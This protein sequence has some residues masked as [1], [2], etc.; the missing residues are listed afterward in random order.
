MSAELSEVLAILD[1]AAAESRKRPIELDSH[2]NV[3]S[4]SVMEGNATLPASGSKYQAIDTLVT[5]SDKITSVTVESQQKTKPVVSKQSQIQSSSATTPLEHPKAS[6]GSNNLVSAERKFDSGYSRRGPRSK[7]TSETVSDDTIANDDD[8]DDDEDDDSDWRG[9]RDAMKKTAAIKD[10]ESRKPEVWGAYGYEES[11]FF[12]NRNNSDTVLSELDIDDYPSSSEDETVENDIV[13]DVVSI[14]IN[15]I[16][17]SENI[18]STE[19]VDD[20]Q[21][22]DELLTSRSDSLLEMAIESQCDFKIR[23]VDDIDSSTVIKSPDKSQIESNDIDPPSPQVRLDSAD[24]PKSSGPG[25]ILQSASQR[26]GNG[27]GAKKRGDRLI[28]SVENARQKREN[29]EASSVS[30][31]V[32]NEFCNSEEKTLQNESDEHI[33]SVDVS[34]PQKSS[35]N[36][37]TETTIHTF[38]K[39]IENFFDLYKIEVFNE[40]Y[41][42]VVPLELSESLL[43]VISSSQS[44]AVS[45]DEHNLVSLHGKNVTSKIWK[46][47]RNICVLQC[48]LFTSQNN[49][50]GGITFSPL[51]IAEKSD[52]LINALVSWTLVK[53]TELEGRVISVNLSC[54]DD[55]LSNEDKSNSNACKILHIA[56]EGVTPNSILFLTNY[57]QQAI[58]DLSVANLFQSLNLDTVQ[59]TFAPN[60]VNIQ[61]STFSRVLTNTES[62]VALE[63]MALPPASCATGLDWQTKL[64]SNS[65]ATCVLKPYV[66]EDPYLFSNVLF[67]CETYGL[68]LCGLRTAYVDPSNTAVNHY[69]HL[70]SSLEVLQYVI[71][72]SNNLLPVI[73]MCYY[74]AK[75]CA[76]DVLRQALGPEDPT[77][78]HRTDPKSVRALYGQSRHKNIAFSF[79]SLLTNSW[80]DTMYWFG[81][82]SNKCYS[83]SRGVCNNTLL[84]IPICRY[85]LFGVAVEYSNDVNHIMEHHNNLLSFIQKQIHSSLKYLTVDM[86]QLES[87]WSANYN[88]FLNYNLETT[89]SVISLEP[90]VYT[91]YQFA[92]SC[93]DLSIKAIFDSL[94]NALALI[95]TKGIWNITVSLKI[96]DTNKRMELREDI[97][98]SQSHLQLSSLKS[99]QNEDFNSHEDVGLQDVIVVSIAPQTL[100]IIESHSHLQNT[101]I[102]SPLDFIMYILECIPSDC[103]TTIIG[104]SSNAGQDASSDKVYVCLRGYHII[105]NIDKS[106]STAIDSICTRLTSASQGLTSPSKLNSL[107]HGSI[108]VIKG[109]RA[110]DVICREFRPTEHTFLKEYALLNCENFVPS[111]LLS[112]DGTSTTDY[113]RV[114]RSLFPP[115]VFNTLSVV[116]IPFVTSHN[117]DMQHTSILLRIL[118]RLEK[119]N[120]SIQKIASVKLDAEIRSMCTQD[121]LMDA[122]LVY[123]PSVINQWEN[124][125]CDWFNSLSEQYVLA[126]VV[127]GNSALRSLRSIIGPINPECAIADYPTS[128]VA[129]LA[130][131]ASNSSKRGPGVFF[132]LTCKTT[133]LMLK[134]I[135]QIGAEELSMLHPLALSLVDTNNREHNSLSDV[136]IDLAASKI[137]TELRDNSKSEFQMEIGGKKKDIRLCEITPSESK[138]QFVAVS[139]VEITCL[140][141]THDLMT[142]HGIGPVVQVIHKEGL[143][144]YIAYATTVKLSLFVTILFYV[145]D[146]PG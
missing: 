56:M 123:S 87:V 30:V 96:R 107:M 55:F 111:H 117:N 36:L 125:V 40:P 92:T 64:N 76:S 67:G 135:S 42:P 97:Y 53:M 18:D 82:R 133:D 21:G 8:D 93:S 63:R 20:S 73:V 119:E 17:E 79:S 69:L 112:I 49:G 1:A 6:S 109:R 13:V 2:F 102:A 89:K 104:L 139:S 140:L 103:N 58:R 29:R 94:R 146:C 127:K 101:I 31:T 14:S 75:A 38:K 80:K 41:C 138:S 99:M 24:E 124:D 10:T 33:L 113:Q 7:M 132:T 105:E 77:L 108:K 78:A 143:K 65:T 46:D 106:V 120:F 34:S 66:L 61:L 115:G 131:T 45:A 72:G 32:E 52:V 22:L 98:G 100:S 74:C 54:K 15:N 91:I 137:I 26:R 95:Q 9:T 136:D 129:T 51:S 142:L 116:I 71:D 39:E 48:D 85:V 134:K 23:D 35:S 110:F 27:G 4:Q 25:G 118:K 114:M 81:P 88:E 122:S 62:L 68:R 5:T 11:T 84:S 44:T 57:I 50:S 47:C 3:N 128:I 83:L 43:E 37:T 90:A 19:V 12:P 59:A 145:L 86:L 70:E 130:S 144:V 16:E 60:E 28:G 121:S 126:V 141:I